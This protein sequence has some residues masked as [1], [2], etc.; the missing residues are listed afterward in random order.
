[1]HLICIDMH[2]Q[3]HLNY[4]YQ[5]LTRAQMTSI[6]KY[7]MY[8]IYLAHCALYTANCESHGNCQ[9]FTPCPIYTGQGRAGQG[10]NHQ[11]GSENVH[12]ALHNRT[13]AYLHKWY[14]YAIAR[15][16]KCAIAN[17]NLH[18]GGI[19]IFAQLCT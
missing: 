17:A 11:T 19:C 14:T 3:S 8:N 13:I 2:R 18:N 15:L 10:S 4:K 6:E 7:T 16:H 12:S 9:E 5:I 1:M